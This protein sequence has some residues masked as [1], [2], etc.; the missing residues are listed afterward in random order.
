MSGIR[1]AATKLI[2][3]NL[4][5]Y[6]KE[7]RDEH[8]ERIRRLCENHPAYRI[9]LRHAKRDLKQIQPAL[10]DEKLELEIIQLYNRNRLQTR[11]RF[12]PGR[13][14]IALGEQSKSA[15]TFRSSL[16][17]SPTCVQRWSRLLNHEMLS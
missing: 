12:E 4:R 6:T 11:E 10:T 14:R 7:P 5:K 17:L 2:R 9:L 15:T 8:F 16:T 1:E 13:Q 3:K